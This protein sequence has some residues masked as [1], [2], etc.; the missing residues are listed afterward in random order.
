MNAPEK[1]EPAGGAPGYVQIPLAV[2]Q[3]LR[4]QIEHEIAALNQAGDDDTLPFRPEDYVSNPI[5]LAR[6]KARL[7][8]VELAERMGVSQAYIS[9]VEGKTQ[10]SAKVLQ[11]VH[12]ALQPVAGACHRA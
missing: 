8:Q 12:Q 2:Y 7:T 1:I 9:K 11:K 10:V 6:I 4:S 3:R 5:A